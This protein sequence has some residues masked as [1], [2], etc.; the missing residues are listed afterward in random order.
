MTALTMPIARC[1][2]DVGDRKRVRRLEPL[3]L[4]LIA[5]VLVWSLWPTLLQMVQRWSNDARYSHGFLVP[6]FSIILLYRRRNLVQTASQVK[7]DYWPGLAFL[8]CGLLAQ[9]AGSYLGSAWIITVSLIPYLL[10]MACIFGGRSG[11][12][13]LLLSV[14]YLGFMIPLPYRIETL[15]GPH[16]QAVATKLSTYII[17]TAGV[18]AFAQGNIIRIGDFRI[19]VLEACSGLSMLMTFLALSVAVSMV[20]ERSWLDRVM[21][22]IVSIPI[23]L[24]ANTGRVVLTAYLS[25]RVGHEAA[26]TFYHDLAGWL[27]IPFALALLWGLARVWCWLIVE[28]EFPNQ[29]LVVLSL[30][31]CHNRQAEP[32]D[33]ACPRID[34]LRTAIYPIV[35]QTDRHGVPGSSGERVQE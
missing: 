31:A 14:L 10:A 35:S 24:F 12:E 22:I 16:L 21:L 3:G 18:M 5:G 1:R 20:I 11:L 15:L 17:Q 13:W 2:T 34:Q 19:G 23:A 28:A 29:S 27:M 9:L 6:L 25:I 4:S 32:I 33:V 7:P 26:E 30:A 8:I